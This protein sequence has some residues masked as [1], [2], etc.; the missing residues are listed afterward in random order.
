MVIDNNFKGHSIEKPP[1][2]NYANIY[3]SFKSP[4]FD[5]TNITNI[6]WLTVMIKISGIG[7]RRK[8][9]R[10]AKWQHQYQL[11]GKKDQAS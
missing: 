10:K 2:V 6:T 5:T 8:C 3:K 9:F 4:D 7:T 1:K 11:I